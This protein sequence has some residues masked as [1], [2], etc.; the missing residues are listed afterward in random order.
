M[1]VAP[2]GVEVAYIEA[3]L[4][5]GAKVL[6]V[7]E[8]VLQQATFAE[9]D[10]TTDDPKVVALALMARTA[11]NYAAMRLLIEEKFIVEAR[12]MVRCCY[13]NFFW[14][15]GLTADGDNFVS[16]IVKA[17]ATATLKRGNELLDWAKKQQDAVDFEGP[18]KTFISTLR[19]NH[20]TPVDISYKAAA[21][22]GKVGDGYIF[23]R[24]LSADA[25]HP[26]ATSLSRYVQYD[27]Q[28]T[29][30]ELRLHGTPLMEEAEVEQTLELG[31]SALLGVCVGTNNLVGGTTAGSQLPELFSQ[32]RALSD[33][34]RA[35][36]IDAVNV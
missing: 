2:E 12:A 14:I 18:L 36:R 30:P 25:A 26:S 11:N 9:D 19:A 24:V 6:T 22:A 15:A 32:F 4:D 31:C 17:D 1:S 20:P 5:L 7:C 28:T 21:D 34:S 35:A 10:K 8:G 23:Y 29:P 16:K 13:E 27:E 3:W 33:K